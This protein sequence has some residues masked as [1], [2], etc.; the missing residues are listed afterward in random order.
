MD[1]LVDDIVELILDNVCCHHEV[2]KDEDGTHMSVDYSLN[3][4]TK[5]RGMIIELINLDKTASK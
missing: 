5:I 3:D 1:K 2:D 4:E